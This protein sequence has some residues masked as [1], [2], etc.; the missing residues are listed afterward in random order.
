[1]SFF[2]PQ[3]CIL[4][5]NIHAFILKSLVI[6]YLKKYTIDV[7]LEFLRPNLY[8]RFIDECV[9]YTSNYDS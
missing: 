7:L 1:M 2:S 4:W 5:E 6:L 9:L 3:V 8:V